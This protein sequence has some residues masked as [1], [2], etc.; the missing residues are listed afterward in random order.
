MSQ[1]LSLSRE[2]RAERIFAIIGATTRSISQTASL[3]AISNNRL[4]RDAH[5]LVS[6]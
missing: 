6:C 2:A 4:F 3:K 5:G 1:S